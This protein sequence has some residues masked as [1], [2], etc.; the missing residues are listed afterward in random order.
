MRI[1]RTAGAVAGGVE[2]P[3]VVAGDV[4]DPD[5]AGVWAVAD[6][7]GEMGA[8]GAVG[9]REARVGV[10][11]T[12][13]GLP[14]TNGATTTALAHTSSRLASSSCAGWVTR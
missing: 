4:V 2:G 9:T 8:R 5:V 10:V 12:G 3:G 13:G 11:E 1:M 7:P 6:S 14:G